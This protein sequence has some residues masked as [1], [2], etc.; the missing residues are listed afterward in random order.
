VAFVFGSVEVRMTSFV[1]DLFGEHGAPQLMAGFGE[2][3]VITIHS[4]TSTGSPLTKTEVSAIVHA[5]TIREVV[6]DGQI[7]HE[8]V[9]SIIVSAGECV[10]WG[11]LT[12][13]KLVSYFVYDGEAW[14]VQEV[15]QKTPTFVSLQCVNRGRRE[16][17]R[18]RYR[19]GA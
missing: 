1:D 13:P 9:R 11:S 5:E 8:R 3:Q 18:T 2:P 17:T 12:N 4:T 14:A 7:M 15:T 10:D 6:Q 19:Q 16:I